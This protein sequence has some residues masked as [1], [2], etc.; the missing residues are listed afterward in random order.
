[1]T[2]IIRYNNLNI[3]DIIENDEDFLTEYKASP[4]YNQAGVTISDAAIKLTY[5]LIVSKYGSNYIL[6]KSVDLF[7][8][9]LFNILWSYGAK[10]ELDLQIQAKLRDL[11]LDEDSEIYQGSKA[12]YNQAAHDETEPS[13]DTDEEL[14]YINNQNVT[15]YRKS[16][17]EGIG[18]LMTLL[19]NDVTDVYIKRYQI[20]FSKFVN[21]DRHILL[22]EEEEE[23]EG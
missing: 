12:I 14:P 20:L 10:W 13:T 23:Y 2:Q 4:F 1:M 9:K 5:A 17:L 11:G 8:L 21:E 22:Y 6:N 15:K 19:R 3:G 16:T 7:K 18:T